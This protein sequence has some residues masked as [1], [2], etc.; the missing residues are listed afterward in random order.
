MPDTDPVTPEVIAPPPAL[1]L[2]TLA[3]GL[4]LGVI[5]P[6]PVFSAP[7]L[8]RGLG[9]LILAVGAIV[10]RWAFVTTQR[11]RANV[12]R[13]DRPAA[14]VVR[15]PFRFS[16]NPVYVGMTAL[17][18]GGAFLANSVWMLFLLVPLLVIMHWGVIVREERF[19]ERQFG[20][21]YLLYKSVTPRWL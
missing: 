9:I 16:R 3:A 10:I 20:D 1:Y 6:L 5:Q 14:L 17:Y 2:G 8:L 18:L 19:L 21:A 4:V 11:T 15:G 13:G 7:V 12:A